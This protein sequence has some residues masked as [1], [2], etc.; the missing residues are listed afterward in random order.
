MTLLKFVYSIW[1]V[2]KICINPCFYSAT[3]SHYS[4]QGGS[5]SEID[6]KTSICLLA[7]ADLSSPCR[8]FKIIQHP[9]CYTFHIFSV[10]ND[11]LLLVLEEKMFIVAFQQSYN[12]TDCNRRLDIFISFQTW[13]TLLLAYFINIS[14]FSFDSSARR[15]N[16][17]HLDQY[18][19]RIL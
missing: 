13:I 7:K 19:K 2:L 11:N 6:Y 10:C 5:T 15:R 9:L 16:C 17:W 14:F 18:E 4:F 3:V 12:R 8:I 1:Q